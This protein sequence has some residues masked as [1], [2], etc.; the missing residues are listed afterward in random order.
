MRG[1]STHGD[2]LAFF[3][4]FVPKVSDGNSN[5]TSASS[6]ERHL[7]SGFTFRAVADGTQRKRG[8]CRVHA[9]VVDIWAAPLGTCNNNPSKT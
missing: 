4:E 9:C 3:W 2:A 6:A 8:F 5:H 7:V 1:T